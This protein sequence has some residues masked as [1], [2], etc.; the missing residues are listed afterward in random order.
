MAFP[1]DEDD[2]NAVDGI[3]PGTF[4]ECLLDVDG[5]LISG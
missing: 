2:E 4:D 1:G 3:I 5:G